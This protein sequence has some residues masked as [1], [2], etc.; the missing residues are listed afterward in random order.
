MSQPI[1]TT[2]SQD[3]YN[4]EASQAIQR[5]IAERGARFDAKREAMLARR[6][7]RQS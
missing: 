7:A 4:V 5:A 2:Q 3:S 1:T 6:A